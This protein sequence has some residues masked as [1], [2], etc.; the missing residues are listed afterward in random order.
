MTIGRTIN[1]PMPTMSIML[2]AV[3]SFNPNDRTKPVEVAEEF[4]S[5]IHNVIL[6]YA[7]Y[8]RRKT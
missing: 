7:N 4:M 8:K 5:F 1:G 3:A 2:R 6:Q